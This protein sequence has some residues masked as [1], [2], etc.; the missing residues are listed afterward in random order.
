M[1]VPAA[2]DAALWPVV[3]I[4]AGAAGLMAASFAA[5][6]GARTLVLERTRMGGK[7]IVVS[8]GG[9]GNVLPSVAAPERFVTDSSPNTLRKML[10]AWPLDDQ[11]RYF[12][13]VLRLPLVLEPETGKLFPASQRATDVRGALLNRAHRAGATLRFD[14]H[15]TGLTTDTEGRWT[16][17]LAGGEIL[18][19]SV[20]LATGGLSVPTTGSDGDGLRFTQALGHALHPTYAALTPL[21]AEPPVHAALAGVSL[22]VRIEAPQARPRFATEDGFLFTHRGYSGP[23]VLDASHVAIRARAAHTDGALYA[24]WTVFDAGAWEAMLREGGGSAG[25]L[26]RRHL[27]A[28]LAEALLAEAGVDDAQPLAQLRRDAR[29]RL[30]TVLTRYPLPHTGD[31]GY[32]KAEVTGGG[33]ALSEVDARTMESRRTP[34]LFLCGELLD[35]F[36]PIGGH[37]FLWAW[38]TGRAAGLGAAAYAAP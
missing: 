34:G 14:T 25:A 6:A 28:R 3:V 35:A 24:R 11:R 7:K 8:G 4:G 22:R 21:L 37:N 17:T 23:S 5:S 18:A 32:R 15:V 26:L 12:E 27:P 20:V 1:S 33:V 16:I 2:D 36:G 30:V 31:E 19:R 38:S 29:A 10:L 13:D 9:R